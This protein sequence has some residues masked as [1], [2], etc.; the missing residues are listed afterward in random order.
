MDSLYFGMYG[1]SVG[2]LQ[3]GLNLFGYYHYND[4]YQVFGWNTY[5]AVYFFQQ[6]YGIEPT[7]IADADTTFILEGL[8]AGVTDSDG[9]LIQGQVNDIESSGTTNVIGRFGNWTFVVTPDL[10][11]SIVGLSIS[12][13]SEMNKSENST[14]GYVSRKGGNPTEISFTYV[15]NA[16]TGDSVKDSVQTVIMGAREGWREYFYI[17]GNKVIEDLLM[18]TDA[19]I[20][21][22]VL[23]PK[24]EWI[25][26][27]AKI[28][29]KQCEATDTYVESSS[30]SGG[31]NS[32]GGGGGGYSAG[33]TDPS[34][35]ASVSSNGVVTK[36][37]NNI[38]DLVSGA[39]ATAGSRART[40]WENAKN[41]RK[42]KVTT[43]TV[44]SGGAGGGKNLNV[45]K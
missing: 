3:W 34:Q 44:S 23:S 10:I 41:A 16:M 45:T 15:F 13:G 19:E 28:T 18:I 26:A 27:D 24:G 39:T 30:S 31:G 25:S 6:A 33:Y 40:A 37:V 36:V 7:G 4:D 38:N 8:I 17:G 21:N 42:D 14:Q 5:Y 22:V 12:A 1:S 20:S 11:K 29:L 2:W 32:G 9:N 35:K 43:T